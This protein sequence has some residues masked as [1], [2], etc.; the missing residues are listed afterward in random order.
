MPE[1][2]TQATPPPGGE[3]A[4]ATVVTDAL[5]VL[6][7]GGEAVPLKE[8]DVEA[9]AAAL[10]HL[11]QRM[12]DLVQLSLRERQKMAHAANL[13]PEVIDRG[14]DLGAAWPMMKDVLGSSAEELRAVL[15]RVARNE[16]LRQVLLALADTLRATNLALKHRTGTTILQI[17]AI[18]GAGLRSKVPDEYTHLR[19]Q[20][21]EMKR[22]ILRV[23]KKQSRKRAKDAEPDPSEE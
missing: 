1:N 16:E 11:Q 6:R 17:Y 18:V 23:R 4:V 22:T 20:Y 10:R 2:D 7:A 15:D 12:P 8:V 3:G 5:P 19:P 13:D 14:L 9:L 21:D